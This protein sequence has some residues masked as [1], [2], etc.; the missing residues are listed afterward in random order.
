MSPIRRSIALAA[1]L[2][3]A[4]VAP[5]LALAGPYPDKPIRLV[6]PFP[7]GGATDLMARTMGQKLAERIGQAVIIDNRAGAGGGIGAEAVATSAPDGYTLL[8]ATMGSLTINP[9]LY[10]NLRY[11]PLKNFA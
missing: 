11:D 7:A 5:G 4:C 10:K 1:A 2:S 3:L 8:F 9:S 6:V